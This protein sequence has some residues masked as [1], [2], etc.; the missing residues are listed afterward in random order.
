MPQGNNSLVLRILTDHTLLQYTFQL[1][2]GKF[3][4]GYFRLAAIVIYRHKNKCLE[5]NLTVTWHL[6]NQIIVATFPLSL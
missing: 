5:D 3:I 1:G 4:K 2:M 6:F